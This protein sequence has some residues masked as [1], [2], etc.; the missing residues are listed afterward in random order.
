MSVI[1]I[2]NGRKTTY[3]QDAYKVW[4]AECGFTVWQTLSDAHEKKE[5]RFYHRTIEHFYLNSIC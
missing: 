5:I 3:V 4:L 2:L 1:D